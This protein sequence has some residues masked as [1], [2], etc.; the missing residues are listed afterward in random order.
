MEEIVAA[1]KAAFI[2]DDIM[3]MPDGFDTKVGEEV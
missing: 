2:Y 3:E 1:A